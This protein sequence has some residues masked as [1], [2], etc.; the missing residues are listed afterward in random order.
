MTWLQ[1]IWL[2]MQRQTGSQSVCVKVTPDLFLSRE[3]RRNLQAVI[4]SVLRTSL[5]SIVP[6]AFPHCESFFPRMPLERS[7]AGSGEPAGSN[8]AATDAAVTVAMVAKQSE[9]LVKRTGPNWT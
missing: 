7:E 4:T 5:T 6:P 9:N 3:S 2:L 1:P 8:D